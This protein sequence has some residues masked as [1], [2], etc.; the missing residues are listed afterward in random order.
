MNRIKH[1]YI[2]SFG[3]SRKYRFVFDDIYENG[4]HK[5]TPL[6]KLENYLNSYLKKEFPGETF[7]YY[8]TPKITE[9]SPEHESQFTSYPP[10]DEKAVEEIKAELKREIMVMNE[11]RQQSSDAPWNDVNA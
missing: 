8:T 7:A 6:V 9:V 1:I 2:V 10:L 5:D 4:K 11:A 3:D